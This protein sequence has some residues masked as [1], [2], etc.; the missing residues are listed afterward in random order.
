MWISRLNEDGGEWLEVLDACECVV[1]DK[2][3]N[4][5]RMALTPCECLARRTKR[6]GVPCLEPG[7]EVGKC[8]RVTFIYYW[9]LGEYALKLHCEAKHLRLYGGMRGIRIYFY[10]G[11]GV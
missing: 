4:L 3:M 11:D 1:S 10:R 8:S 5:D 7:S 6:A 9:G 2:R